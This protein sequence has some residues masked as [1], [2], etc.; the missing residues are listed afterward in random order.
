MTKTRTANRTDSNLSQRSTANRTAIRISAKNR[1][2]MALPSFCE[3]CF[4]TQLCCRFRVPFS[5]FPGVFSPF[6]VAIK[7]LVEAWYDKH[8]ELP[9]WLHEVG[10]INDYIEPHHS[11]RDEHMIDPLLDEARRIY[12]LPHPP[13]KWND[14]KECALLSD[15]MRACS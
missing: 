10:P 2:G 7:R 1:A 15:L 11:M 9:V 14:C 4:W 8:N 5:K 6:D 12:D 13:T 3:R